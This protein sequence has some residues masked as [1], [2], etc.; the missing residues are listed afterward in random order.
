ML[1]GS[2]AARSTIHPGC[3]PRSTYGL[4]GNSPGSSSPR[5]IKSSRD[6]LP[7]RTESFTTALVRV[8]RATKTGALYAN[9]VFLIGF[10]LGTIRV[11]LLAPRLGETT[12]VIAEVP[13]ML[14]ASWFV[15]RWCVD[16]LNVRRTVPARSLMGLVAFLVLMSAKV[17][18]GVVLGRSIVDRLAM[19]K[20]PSGA[21]GLAAQV[22]FAY[23][24]GYSGLAAVGHVRTRLSE[25]R[26]SNTDG[27]QPTR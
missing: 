27:V 25:Q 7:D 15:C 21:I 22:I 1:S 23:L 3:G 11:L 8:F 20:S 26:R 24:P 18:L 10:I 6:S 12:A 4:A 9:I 14:A 13:M 2:G 16:R 5:A 17:E 19:Y